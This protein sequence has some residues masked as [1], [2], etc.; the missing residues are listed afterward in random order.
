[1]KIEWPY[2]DAW[3]DIGW[4]QAHT[5]L[6]RKAVYN[7]CMDYLVLEVRIARKWG[8]RFRLWDS[9]MRMFERKHGKTV[10]QA[11]EEKIARITRF[12]AADER[13]EKP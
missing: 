1:M 10:E 7:D 6:W 4:F 3:I 13:K 8:F 9:Y 12:D 5:A 11:R 2:L